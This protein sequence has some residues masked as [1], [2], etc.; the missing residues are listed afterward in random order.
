MQ[1]MHEQQLASLREAV[2][3]AMADKEEF[4]E[5]LG[6]AQEKASALEEALANSNA[7]L[8]RL[9]T[10]LKSAQK[11][12]RPAC[13]SRVPPALDAI[14]SIRIEQC[15]RLSICLVR[16]GRRPMSCRSWW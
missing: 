1:D 2:T 9:S 5:L 12:V 4:L 11:T 16:H 10:E 3:A 7:E 15:P 13:L 14:L 6:Q 8:R